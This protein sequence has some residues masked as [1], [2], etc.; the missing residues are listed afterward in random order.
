MLSHFCLYN[1]I[2]NKIKVKENVDTNYIRFLLDKS[3]VKGQTTIK[4]S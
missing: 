2:E 3:Q 1:P 4:S